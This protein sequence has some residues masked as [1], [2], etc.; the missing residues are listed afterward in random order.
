MKHHVHAQADAC[1]TYSDLEF[2]AGLH[3]C[4]SAA[5]RALV[6]RLDS[7]AVFL[8]AN[9]VDPFEA[10][11]ELKCVGMRLLALASGQPEPAARPVPQLIPVAA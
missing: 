5:V 9:A 7:L 4:R 3:Q 2:L 10:A 11:D 1:N 6:I 8:R